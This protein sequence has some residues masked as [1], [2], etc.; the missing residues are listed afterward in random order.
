M[1]SLLLKYILPFIASVLVGYFLYCSFIQTDLVRKEVKM[2]L[3][4]DADQAS[5]VQFFMEDNKQFKVENMRSMKIDAPAKN[6][7]LLY[8]IPFVYNPGR[9]RLDPGL[10][11]G[12]WLVKKLVFKGLAGDISYSP[13]ELY[14]KF[15]P[16][17]DIKTFQLIPGEGL[18][19]ESNGHDPFIIS[20]F[21]YAPFF[22]FLNTKPRIYYFPLLLSLS[23]AFFV[24]YF[25]NKRLG[26]FV[27]KEITT[28]HYFVILFL[29]LLTLPLIWKSFF[30]Q[31]ANSGENRSLQEK[32]VFSISEIVKYPKRFN[33][34]FEDNFGFRKELSTLNSYYKLKLFNASSKPELVAVGKNSWLFSTD[35][36]VVGDYQ[37][38][39][40]FSLGEL[41]TIQ[42]NLEEAYDWY[43]ARGIHFFVMIMPVKSNIYPE[44]LP[45]MIKREK[46]SS[47]LQQLAG[48]MEKN[49]HVK[50]IDASLDLINAKPAAEVYYQHDI[51]MN[52]QGGFI[53]YKRLMKAINEVN[54]DLKAVPESDYEKVLKH[55]H[56][57]DLSRQL[58]LEHVL[59]NDEWHLEKKKEVAYE[60]VDPPV[61]ETASILQPTVRT[62][63]KNSKL[64]KAVVYRDS[65]FNLIMPYFSENFSD[66]IYIWS[67]EMSV[68]VI[69]KETPG[70]VVY[71]FLES[72]IDKL[73]EDNPSGIRKK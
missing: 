68:E 42:Y 65:F 46:D 12:K 38:R 3:I 25:L 19:V 23:L 60:T 64:P 29:G 32:P 9:I 2:E 14:E 44:Y 71:E 62:Q 69:D 39:K 24:F 67:K 5:D 20:K 37:N 17:N 49:S 45:D 13:E 48:F 8:E 11:R 22:I 21:S 54:P 72:G 70:Y 58:S 27:D 61:Y 26:A 36:S 35:Q 63:I 10:T 28:D 6:I 47:K 55:I 31:T 1:K 73:L 7:R 56:N 41:Q 4:L 59:L 34:Y 18:L 16:E 52:F 43:K 53:A 30:P 66:C 40:L 57:A 51:H 15:K 33:S 50:I